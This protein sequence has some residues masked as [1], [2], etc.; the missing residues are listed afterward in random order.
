M[1][2]FPFGSKDYADLIRSKQY[3]VYA[4]FDPTADSLHIGNLL[5]L[6][7][8]IHFMRA[9]IQPIALVMLKSFF[10]SSPVEFA[11]ER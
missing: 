1:S 7:G 4:G 11:L 5:P 6:I 8:L 3:A 2:L 9:G 10:V